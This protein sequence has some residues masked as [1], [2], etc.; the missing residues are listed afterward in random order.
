[1]NASDTSRESVAQLI[2]DLPTVATGWRSKSIVAQAIAT[3]DALAKERDEANARAKAFELLADSSE[4]KYQSACANLTACAQQC[5]ELRAT[6]ED[7]KTQ[8][9]I[10]VD[11]ARSTQSDLNV[12]HVKL[13]AA[14]ARE[15]RLA[16]EVVDHK[17]VTNDAREM[18]RAT[19]ANPAKP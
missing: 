2:T 14:L 18:A 12:M 10:A 6:L 19:L 16:R 9:T 7:A 8:A 15:A 17:Y 5:D 13:T 11:L 3:L 1:M 4:G